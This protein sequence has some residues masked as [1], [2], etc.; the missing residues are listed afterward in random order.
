MNKTVLCV[1]LGL[2]VTALATPSLGQ[3]ASAPFTLACRNN[4]GQT[5]Y[6]SIDL[7]RKK[8][9]LMTSSGKLQAEIQAV[10][11]ETDDVIKLKNPGGYFSVNR[12]SGFMDLIKGE[13]RKVDR[14][15][16]ERNAQYIQIPSSDPST[17]KF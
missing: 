15:P 5:I 3:E 14:I 16:C 1:W 10:T 4:G 8:W 9:A 12:K 17:N 7:Q 6:F 2:A 13:S 11:A